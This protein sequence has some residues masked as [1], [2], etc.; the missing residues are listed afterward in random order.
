M[1]ENEQYFTYA[2]AVKRDTRK[3]G[4]KDAIGGI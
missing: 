1:G 4:K 2:R 3:E